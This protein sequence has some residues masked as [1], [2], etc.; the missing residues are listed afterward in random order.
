M[1]N[2]MPFNLALIKIFKTDKQ[3]VLRAAGRAGES[4]EETLSKIIYQYRYGTEKP[5]AE[6]DPRE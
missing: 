5:P 6:P 3:Y 4:E 1:F 2:P